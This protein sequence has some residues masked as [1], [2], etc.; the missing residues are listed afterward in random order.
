[1]KNIVRANGLKHADIHQKRRVLTLPGYFRPTKLWDL[2]VMNEGRLIAALEFKSH[3]GPSFG[4]NFNNRTEEAIGTAHD[5]WTAYREGAFGEQTKPFIGWLM[6]LEDCPKSSTPVKGNSPHFPM[7]PEFRDAS[8]AQRYNVLCRKLMQ[9]Q[10]YTVACLL[11][12]P[13]S[14]VKSGK[15]KELSDMTGLRTFVSELA[16]HVAA[17]SARA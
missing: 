14:A 1:M 5:L 7:F 17:E 2:L 12:S 13:R 15:F 9:E 3:V 11:T 8:Y 4:N 16:G 6:L 10:L